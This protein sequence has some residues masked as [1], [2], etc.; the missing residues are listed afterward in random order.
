MLCFS[1]I[2]LFTFVSQEMHRYAIAGKNRDG[3]SVT[4]FGFLVKI[5]QLLFF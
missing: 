1:S 2:S 5:R 4:S 3:F